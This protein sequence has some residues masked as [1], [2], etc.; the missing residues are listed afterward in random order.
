MKKL[1]IVDS[2]ELFAESLIAFLHN[3]FHI[4]VCTDSSRVPHELQTYRP[5]FL[6]I[7]VYL[8]GCDGV[9]L[10]RQS[11]YRVPHMLAMV[12]T[13]TPYA[14]HALTELGAEYILMYPCAA[15]AVA[16]HL[17]NMARLSLLPK[18]Q[19]DPREI[20][21]EHLRILGFQDGK[22]GFPQLC[23]AIPLFAQ[24][25][26]QSLSKEL[27]PAVAQICGNAS[28]TQVESQARRLIA[29]TWKN[30][31]PAVWAEYFPDLHEKPTFHE[32]LY[33]LS[34]KLDLFDRFMRYAQNE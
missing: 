11:G 3:Q 17:E 18:Q 33:L 30:R 2:S 8:P 27:Q 20:V 15:R 16:G 22:L 10:L 13:P 21:R 12:P 28:G 6:V 9:T 23:V 7:N 5:D 32:F 26:Y 24:D 25:P 1:L 14:V 4:R 19:R 31:N 34:E 29:E